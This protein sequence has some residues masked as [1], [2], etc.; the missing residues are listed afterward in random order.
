[1]LPVVNFAILYCAG[2]D[3]VSLYETFNKRQQNAYL[4]RYIFNQTDLHGGPKVNYLE[5][6]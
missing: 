2:K 6:G 5:F 1:M 3:S 4:V